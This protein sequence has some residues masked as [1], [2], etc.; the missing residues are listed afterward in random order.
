MLKYF[1]CAQQLR[2]ITE[3]NTKND[4][5]IILISDSSQIEDLQLIFFTNSNAKRARYSIKH[6]QN[7]HLIP[8]LS[9]KFSTKLA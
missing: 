1:Y 7:T 4:N 5:S 9:L 2:M 6:N 3:P 8:E